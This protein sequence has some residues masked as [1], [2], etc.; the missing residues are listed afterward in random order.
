MYAYF[1]DLI[2]CELITGGGKKQFVKDLNAPKRPQ[3]ASFL[4][5]SDN[6]SRIK[7]ENPGFANKDLLKITVQEWQVL[8]KETFLLLNSS[9]F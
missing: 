7:G 2:S 8:D 9:F 4:W 6:M 3:T 1:D 5:L